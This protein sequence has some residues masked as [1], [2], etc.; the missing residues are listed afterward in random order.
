MHYPYALSPLTYDFDSLEPYMDTQQLT[1]H[2]T[3]HHQAYVDQL[4]KVM[5]PEAALHTIKLD[6]LLS[7]G[8]ELPEPLKTG[9]IHFGGGVYNHTFFWK[10]LHPAEIYRPSDALAQALSATF[11]SVPHFQEQLS[12]TALDVF[13][14]GWAWLCLNQ[15]KQLVITST[16]N[17]DCPLSQNLFPLL[18]IDVWEHAY[19]IQ[20]QNRR[21][22]FIHEWWHIINWHFVQQRYEL[23]MH[24]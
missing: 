9:I 23:G 6:E 1:V 5:Q 4:N 2:Y 12:K 17:Q 8:S 14:S 21:A 22:D 15:E 19:Y 7:Q 18:C 11:G 24:R 20:Y 16:A 13:G 3:K 10:C